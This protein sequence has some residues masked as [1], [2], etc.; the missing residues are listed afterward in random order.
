VSLSDSPTSPILEEQHPEQDAPQAESSSAM[1]DYY[2]LQQELFL[3]TLILTGIIFFSV[4]GFYTLNTALSYLLGSCVGVLYLR[5][6]ARSVER[7]TPQSK[8]RGSPTRFVL[9]AGLIIIALQWNQLEFIPAFL[10]FLT[11]KV[12]VVVYTLRITLLSTEV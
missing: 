2:A 4:W 10:G 3:T 1:E 7:M 6:L 8:R 11:Y 9:F 5:M 12:A